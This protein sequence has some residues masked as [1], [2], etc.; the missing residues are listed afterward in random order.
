[1]Y[2]YFYVNLFSSK[3]DKY[4]LPIILKGAWRNLVLILIAISYLKAA[5]SLC[6]FLCSMPFSEF[7]SGQV[8]VWGIGP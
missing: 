4:N 8:A 7:F 6:R 5:R 2:L 1:V 3:E